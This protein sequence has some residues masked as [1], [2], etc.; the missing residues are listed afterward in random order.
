MAILAI[1][2]TSQ[3]RQPPGDENKKQFFISFLLFDLCYLR[4]E[5][6]TAEEGEYG[7]SMQRTW[8]AVARPGHILF[9]ML[10]LMHVNMM[11]ISMI[12]DP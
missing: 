4:R 8:Q 12:P 1:A 2:M 10:I 5:S 9:Q 6:M 3:G 7:G 11:Q